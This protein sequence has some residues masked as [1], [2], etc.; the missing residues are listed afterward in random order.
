MD[1]DSPKTMVIAPKPAT[2]RSIL[3]P[4]FERSGYQA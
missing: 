3:M 2:A 4:T 1:L